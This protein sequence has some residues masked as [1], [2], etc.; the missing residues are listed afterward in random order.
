MNLNQ[1]AYNYSSGNWYDQGYWGGWASLGPASLSA[2]FVGDGT[3]HTFDSLWSYMYSGT[4]GYWKNAGMNLNQFA[5]NYSSGNWYNQGNW[6][7][8]AALGAVLPGGW[9]SGGVLSTPVLSAAFVGDGNWHTLDSTWSY[10]YASGSGYWKESGTLRFAYNYTTGQW[11]DSSAY[12]YALLG[13]IWSA[14]GGAVGH[15][16]STFFGDGD[17]HPTGRTDWDYYYD[18]ANGI[19]AY[20]NWVKWNSTTATTG[21]GYDYNY[22]TGQWVRYDV[23]TYWYGGFLIAELRPYNSASNSL[24][25]KLQQYSYTGVS[26]IPAPW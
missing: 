9:W 12:N 21:A 23:I 22:S 15:Q 13:T 3:L 2:S 11:S 14:I 18:Q 20:R 25:S 26:S 19:S 1:F 5:Y 24:S 10:D 8:W 17:F 6:G 16:A 4:Y 7:G